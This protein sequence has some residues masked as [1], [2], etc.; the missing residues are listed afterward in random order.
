M[1]VEERYKPQIFGRTIITTDARNIDASNVR[2]VLLDCYTQHLSNRKR[3]RYLIN[4]ERGLQPLQR[5]KEVR[6]DVDIRVCDNLANEI[7]EF[8][9]GYKWG[10]PITY[11]QRAISDT[12]GNNTDKDNE[13]IS[14]INEMLNEN[15]SFREDAKLAY[16]VEVCGIGYQMVDIKKDFECTAVFDIVTLDPL[17]TFIVRDNSVFHR[18]LMGVTYTTDNKGDMYF[19]CL[20]AEQRF[21]IVGF[22]K[23]VNGVRKTELNE[24][25]RSGE[26]NPMHR[27]NIVE[28]ERSADRMGAWERQISD[29]DNVNI[30]V[31]D[32]VNNVAQDT[33]ALW[34]G[35]NLDLPEE[36]DNEGVVVGYK[37]PRSGGW[38]LTSSGEQKKASV[39]PL[40]I[41]TQYEGILNNIKYRRDVIK[42]KCCVPVQQSTGGGSTGSAMSMSSGWETAEVQAQKEESFMRKA[43]M[44]VA[45]LILI[46]VKES[47]DTP[48]D[49]PILKLNISDIQP[50]ILRD[51]NYDMATKANTL[52]TLMRCGVSAEHA[53]T[54]IKLFSDPQLVL[55]DSKETLDLYYEQMKVAIERSKN[56]SGDFETDENWQPKQEKTGLQ[57]GSMQSSNSPFIDGSSTSTGGAHGAGVTK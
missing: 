33:Q 18:P 22:S 29:M 46:A 49:S 35:D 34:W 51:R 37:I 43:K 10:Q 36:L 19:T 3:M 55:N 1:G 30:L 6:K 40:I 52:A 54:V 26:M 38:I 45:R 9:T 8:K 16:Y 50:N 13:G 15:D 31:S 41:Q 7:T 27:V 48:K 28:F 14:A 47:T 53:F 5:K 44:E 32:F 11:K 4:Y 23:I 21:D 25:N 12:H 57:D 2:E 56:T 24:L 17:N 42:Q 39:Q 20:T